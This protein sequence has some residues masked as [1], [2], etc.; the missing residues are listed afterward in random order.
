MCIFC[1]IVAGEIP[2]YKVYEDE[3][4]FAFL[5]IEPV[6]PGHIL[7][8][9]KK[10]V[11]NIEEVTEAEL[12]A[13]IIAVKKMG[14]LLKDKLGY[15]AYNIHQNNGPLAGQSV[16]HLHFHLIPRLPGDDLNHWPAREYAPGEADE[17]LKKLVA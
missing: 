6:Q 9:P 5:D 10:H 16:L 4:I 2:A 11:A 17:I 13:L 15:E 14:R 1:Q 12:T 7:V 3:K 8:L